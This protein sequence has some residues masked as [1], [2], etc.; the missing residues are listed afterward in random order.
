MPCSQNKVKIKAAMS[1]EYFNQ[2][3][4]TCYGYFGKQQGQVDNFDRLSF[5]STLFIC[6]FNFLTPS[7]FIRMRRFAWDMADSPISVILAFK[8]LFSLIAP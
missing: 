7:I 8:D 1:H 5:F 6:F 2:G 3:L 4:E